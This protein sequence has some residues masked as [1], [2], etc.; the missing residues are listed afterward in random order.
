VVWTVF[1]ARMG[2]VRFNDEIARRPRLARYAG[3]VKARPSFREA[4]VWDRLSLLK[5]LKQVF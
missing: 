4:D 1:L 3:A 5:M 2:F